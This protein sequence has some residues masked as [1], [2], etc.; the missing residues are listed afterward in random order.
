V[1]DGGGIECAALD[2]EAIVPCINRLPVVG[3]GLTLL[4]VTSC[5]RSAPLTVPDI[6]NLLLLVPMF[7]LSLIR[8]FVVPLASAAP[9]RTV[10][11][12]EENNEDVATEGDLGLSDRLV[13]KSDRSVLPE[14][15]LVCG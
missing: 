4:I 15:W 5:C 1:V 13:V 9:L 6:S 14:K 12:P 2:L 7:N 3:T 10:P 8:P 11:F